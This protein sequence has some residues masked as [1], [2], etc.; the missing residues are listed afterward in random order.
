MNLN[1]QKNISNKNPRKKDIF[2]K[3]QQRGCSKLIKM[4]INLWSKKVHPFTCQLLVG[5][6]DASYECKAENCLDYSA[7]GNSWGLRHSHE[8]FP[9]SVCLSLQGAWRSFQPLQLLL[10]T[11]PCND[12]SYKKPQ[13]WRILNWK[14]G[15]LNVPPY[16][17]TCFL[18]L[19]F[20]YSR[21]FFCHEFSSIS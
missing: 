13:W 11:Q 10:H 12:F 6:G 9:L 4:I 8:M 18:W 21:G 7:G 1:L 2:I 3:N 15:F 14:K 17:S 20:K 16:P 5:N 19:C